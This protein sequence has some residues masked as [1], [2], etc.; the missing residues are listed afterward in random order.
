[1]VLRKVAAITLS[2]SSLDFHC[3]LFIFSIDLHIETCTTKQ[4]YLPLY[5]TT[6]TLVWLYSPWLTHCSNGHVPS[7][8]GWVVYRLW[9]KSQRGEA[10]RRTFNCSTHCYLCATY[11][12]LHFMLGGQ[13]HLGKPECTQFFALSYLH[14]A[15]LVSNQREEN[16]NQS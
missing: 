1:M 4:L 3:R 5:W 10:T 13:R 8:T 11:I 7:F 15:E 14:R 6:L 16:C 12:Y 9:T 2:H